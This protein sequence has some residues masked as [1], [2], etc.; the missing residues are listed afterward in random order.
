MADDDDE[1]AGMGLLLPSVPQPMAM[2]GRQVF[3]WDRIAQFTVHLFLLLLTALGAVLFFSAPVHCYVP[4]LTEPDLASGV[5]SPFPFSENS[6]FIAD[7]CTYHIRT[8]QFLFVLA[9]QF[10]LLYILMHVFW[11]SRGERLQQLSNDMHSLMSKPRETFSQAIHDAA[12]VLFKS[13]HSFRIGDLDAVRR[14]TKLNEL[15]RW[16]HPLPV[17]ERYRWSRDALLSREWA[18][19]HLAHLYPVLTSA[20]AV[21]KASIAFNASYRS[22]AQSVTHVLYQNQNP[23]DLKE[24]VHSAAV[25]ELMLKRTQPHDAWYRHAGRICTAWT[26]ACV[27]ETGLWA[28]YHALHCRTCRGTST[29]KCHCLRWRRLCPN[30]AYPESRNSSP[31]RWCCIYS[32]LRVLQ[33]VAVVICGVLWLRLFT[34]PYFLGEQVNS[35]HWSCDLNDLTLFQFRN[36]SSPTAPAPLHPLAATPEFSTLSVSEVLDLTHPPSV[37]A[38]AGVAT[39]AA[40]AASRTLLQDLAS[41]TMPFTVACTIPAGPMLVVLWYT[42]MALLLL[43]LFLLVLG[44]WCTRHWSSDRNFL[45]YAAHANN[46]NAWPNP[47]PIMHGM[48]RWALFLWKEKEKHLS[49][50]RL[51]AQGNDDHLQ[52]AKLDV[53]NMRMALRPSPYRIHFFPAILRSLASEARFYRRQVFR[54][55]EALHNRDNLVRFDVQKD[56]RDLDEHDPADCELRCIHPPSDGQL[57]HIWNPMAVDKEPL[58]VIRRIIEQQQQQQQQHQLQMQMSPSSHTISLAEADA[59][60]DHMYLELVVR[61]E[62][63]QVEPFQ[64][65]SNGMALLRL[66]CLLTGVECSPAY[67]S[68]R[69]PAGGRPDELPPELLERLMW[70]WTRHFATCPELAFADD[71]QQQLQQQHQEPVVRVRRL[72]LPRPAPPPP[73]PEEGGMV[74]DTPATAAATPSSAFLPVLPIVLP[75]SVSLPLPTPLSNSDPNTPS[76]QSLDAATFASTAGVAVGMPPPIP[77]PDCG[78]LSLYL[79]LLRTVPE[80]CARLLNIPLRS[81]RRRGGSQSSM[82]ELPAVGIETPVAEE[83]LSRAA[84]LRTR[85]VEIVRATAPLPDRLTGAMMRQRGLTLNDLARPEMAQ[86][87]PQLGLYAMH[88][89]LRDLQIEHV[90]RIFAAMA[91]NNA[92]ILLQH[93]CP[94]LSHFEREQGAPGPVHIDLAL[95][96]ENIFLPIESALPMPMPPPPAQAGGHAEQEQEHKQA[97]PQTAPM[98]VHLPPDTPSG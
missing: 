56:L 45:F 67:Q 55:K 59:R 52:R 73:P 79:T 22:K 39:S 64:D 54:F 93:P 48:L 70:H 62:Q 84:N 49:Q 35:D 53:K 17:P 65:G 10:I 38:A 16:V 63:L 61:T 32:L 18:L 82:H 34:L 97:E 7:M 14:N 2:R 98:V 47:Q 66:Y 6:R 42:N 9:V 95:L 33:L 26:C 76:H 81:L 89:L 75:R 88:L 5:I 83:E 68:A 23:A 3:V 36:G 92:P 25:F 4:Q 40:G 30:A 96:T 29:G 13:Q 21:W 19:F 94:P 71:E 43:L 58:K 28:L 37:A 11:W 50:M 77:S 80:L 51:H 24:N 74:P 85:A 87:P 15:C 86:L 69:N 72:M 1:E 31:A 46:P 57:I 8:P 12:D 41:Y 20:M 27:Q 91:E 60:V 90:F 44:C 78:P